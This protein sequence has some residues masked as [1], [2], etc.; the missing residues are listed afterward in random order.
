MRVTIIGMGSGAPEVL[1]AQQAQALCAADMLCGARR[2]LENLPE[3]CTQNRVYTY[4]PEEMLAAAAQAGCESPAFLYSGDTGFYSGAA[5]VTALL[6]QKGIEFRVLPGLSSVQLMAAALGRP[7]QNWRLVSAHGAACDTVAECAGGAPTFF[8]TGGDSTPASLCADLTA[9]RLGDTWATVGE[10]LGT[11]K[12]HVV[13]GTARE[14]SAQSF[15]ALSV[16]LVEAVPVPQRRCAGLPDE[17][18]CR[19]EVPMTKQEVRAAALAKLGVR[20]TDIVWD[21]GAGTGSVSVELALAAPRGHAYAVECSADACALIE[22]NR[23]K[24]R[25]YNLDIIEGMAPQALEELPAPDAVF[26]GGTKGNMAAVVEAVLAKNPAA[27]V[28]VSAIALET[29]Q[30][31]VAALTGAG[32]DVQVTQIAVSR[33]RTAGRLHLL[34]A[35]NPIFLITGNCS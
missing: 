27:R 9:A 21:I 31:A 24:F 23:E 19:G 20:P 2:L 6:R 15:D 7:W 25:A 30:A 11:E 33:T 16:L 32:L 12:Q 10:R 14:L 18:F 5:G 1:S 34:T 13:E 29:L 26:V 28:C 17:A 3:Y 4:K 8:L 22:Q 35:N